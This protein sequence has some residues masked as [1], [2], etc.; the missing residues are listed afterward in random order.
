[1]V[2]IATLLVAVNFLPFTSVQ[3]EPESTGGVVISEV[4]DSVSTEEYNGTD[5]NGDGSYG[6][7]SDQFIELWNNG[8]SPINISNWW[9]MAIEWRNE[10][11]VGSDSRGCTFPEGSILQADE[12]V[13]VFSAD[14]EIRIGYFSKHSIIL[15][16]QGTDLADVHVDRMEIPAMSSVFDTSFVPDGDGGLALAPLDIPVFCKPCAPDERKD[17]YLELI[18]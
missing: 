5:W 16:A 9:L 17:S 13:A 6:P 11:E 3:A 18:H 4:L 7:E 14:S 2:F 8:D 12:R 10:S 1:M 15:S